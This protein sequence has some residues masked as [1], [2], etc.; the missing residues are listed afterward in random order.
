MEN[1]VDIA[2]NILF[3]LGIFIGLSAAYYI[4]F[5]TRL[6]GKFL[7]LLLAKSGFFIRLLIISYSLYYL[8]VNLPHFSGKW[9]VLEYLGHFNHFLVIV[10]LI[11]IAV[12]LLFDYLIYGKKQF[13]VPL[14]FKDIF[15]GVLYLIFILYFLNSV[16]QINITPLLTTSAIFSIILGLALQESLGNLF[17]GLTL[18]LSQPYRVGEWIKCGA[19]EGEVIKINWRATTIR[20]FTDD[21]IM[22]PNSNLSKAEI[23]NYSIPYQRHATYIEVP[24]AY[25]HPPHRILSL[26]REIAT[27]TAGVL[28]DPEPAFVLKRFTPYAIIY[29][30][31]I[32]VDNFTN[33]SSIE[34]AV[35]ENIW[36]R[37]SREGIEVPYPTQNLYL[38]KHESQTQRL[39]KITQTLKNI[40]FL[41]DLSEENF[42]YLSLCA[43]NQIFNK[44]E[45]IV[46]QG[47][48]GHNFY[49][50]ES[51]NVE[52]TIQNERGEIIFTHALFPDD[53][54]GEMSLLTGEPRSAT[55]R[56]K[57][58]TK[59]LLL[60]KEDFKE[61]LKNNPELYD[62]ISHIL[63]KRK[64]RTEKSVKESADK[65]AMVLTEEENQ[66]VESLSQQILKHI[67]N[68]F[69][70]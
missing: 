16:L 47:H 38:L 26:L 59:V 39:K 64:I 35:L 19:Y 7:S 49:I 28:R 69:S 43:K 36:Y 42:E 32:W 25:K 2:Q 50:I 37:F 57:T 44:D 60:E 27:T 63:A 46:R 12:V 41:K 3:T 11:E 53:C 66:Q 6:K 15:K 23:Q 29:K 55:V 56:A 24:V 9:K 52:V 10:I 30:I 65:E 21:Y 14:L 51:G 17:S 67:Q 5:K 58:E 1:W 54:F 34:S 31:K 13:D 40:D 45:I 18:H 70:F 61:L 48:P 33:A 62:K 22:I 8:I 4:I 20:T 68:F